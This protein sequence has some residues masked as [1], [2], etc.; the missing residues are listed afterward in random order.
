MNASQIY[1]ILSSTTLVFVTILFLAARRTGKKLTPLDRFAWALILI[2]IIFGADRL[3][4]YGF[5]GVGV[6][7]AVIDVYIAPKRRIS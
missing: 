6:V 7:L 4:G 5:I 2:G 3:I 1:L